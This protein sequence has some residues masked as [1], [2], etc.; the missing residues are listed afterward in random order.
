VSKNIYADAFKLGIKPDELLTVTQW[1]DKYRVLPQESSAE[2]GPWNTRRTP[3]LREIQDEL[4]PTSPTEDVCVVKGTQL[5]FTELANNLIFTYIDRYPCPIIM[6]MPTEP[7]A[8]KHASAKIDPSIKLMPHIHNKI[9]RAKTKDDA[10]GSREKKFTGGMFSLA[11]AHSPSSF[12]S[13][14]ARVAIGDDI[15]RFPKNVGGEGS[16]LALLNNRTNAFSNRKKYKNSTPVLDGESNIQ[17]E[18]DQSS[19]AEYN[20][21]CPH[22]RELVVFDYDENSEHNNFVFKYDQESYQL[23]DEPIVFVCPHCDEDIQEH[24]KEWMM[25]EDNGAKYVHKY[26]ERKYRGYRVNS[27]YSPLGWLTWRAI[28][29]EYLVALKQ[30]EEEGENTLMIACVTTKFARPYKKKIDTTKTEEILNLKNKLNEGIV[31]KN[32]I[33][34]TMAVDVQ[35]DH[36]WFTVRAWQYGNHKQVIR[37]GRLENWTDIEDVA[38]TPYYT[39]DGQAHHVQHG[40]IDSGYDTQTVYDFCSMNS[41]VFMPIKGSETQQEA[42]RVSDVEKD[43]NGK[44]VD[45]GMK[46]YIIKTSHYKDMLHNSITNSLKATAEDNTKVSN[47][48]GFHAQTDDGITDLSRAKK[49]FAAQM[50]SEYKHEEE[51][52]KGV[53]TYSWRKVTTKA[54]NHLWDCEVYQTFMGELLGIRFLK[55]PVAQ[56]KQAPVHQQQT[57]TSTH[58][59]LSNY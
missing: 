17:V 19:Q 50:T 31:P 52:K 36:F 12:A 30:M 5:G 11:H 54:D 24:H 8:K 39:E 35:K 34:L 43:E 10:G 7:L 28:F 13:F 45:T 6:V 57:D 48:I 40:F 53:V 20:M 44:K 9:E 51:N 2:H 26:P 38:H 27:F 42:Y 32:T 1:A 49:S 15:D 16:S 41:D 25:D 22:C 21:P 14:S 55:A 58:D 3:F 46:L 23:T 33:I 47:T 59:D 18:H 56:K 4:S 29:T 37:Y